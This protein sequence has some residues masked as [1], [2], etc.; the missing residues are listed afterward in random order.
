MRSQ[1]LTILHNVQS[2]QSPI[3][4]SKQQ[5]LQNQNGANQAEQHVMTNSPTKY[6]HILSYSIRG[7]AFIRS[8]NTMYKVVKVP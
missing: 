3:Y 1:D 5:I 2:S 8:Y 7:D 6:E 4:N